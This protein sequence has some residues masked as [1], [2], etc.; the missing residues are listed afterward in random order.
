M[1]DW[2]ARPVPHVPDVEA[3]LPFYAN[4]LGFAS[5]WRYEEDGRARVAQVERQACVLTLD[6]TW[7]ERIGEGLMFICV[8]VEQNTREAVIAALDALPVRGTR[9]QRRSGQGGLWGTGSWLSMI[10]TVISS[11]FNYP[12]EIASGKIIRDEE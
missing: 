11:F 6:G 7:P 9:S 10:P 4:R 3:S 12:N 1:T 2:F 5:P 8:N